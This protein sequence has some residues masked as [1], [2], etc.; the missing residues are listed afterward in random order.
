MIRLFDDFLDQLLSSWKPV[1]PAGTCS[2]DE[3]G[4][5]EKHYRLKPPLTRSIQSLRR[6]SLICQPQRST[7]EAKAVAVLQFS[8][9]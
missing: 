1:V 8:R 3:D 5:F 9:H 4:R 7:P 6:I 2:K